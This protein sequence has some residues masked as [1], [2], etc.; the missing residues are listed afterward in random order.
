ML[1]PEP[2]LVITEHPEPIG[3]QGQW[4]GSGRLKPPPNHDGAGA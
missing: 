4:S 1:R 3:G 2:S